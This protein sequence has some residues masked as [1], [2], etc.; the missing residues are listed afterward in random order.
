MI[1]LFA[2][3]APAALA[4][5]CAA[6]VEGDQ[7]LLATPLA[8]TAGAAE[9]T[10]ESALPVQGIR[11]L[12]AEEPM[13]TVQVEVHTDSQGSDTWN[14]R[15]SQA[16]A[17]AVRASILE[18]GPAPERVTAVG[19]GELYPIDTNSTAAGRAQ[20]RRVELHTEPPE[21]RPPRPEA[22]TGCTCRCPR[23][24]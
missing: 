10:P 5:P 9:I 23:A 12:M 4:I 3:F 11:C 20:N 1:V 14:L 7:V 17:D 24:P 8:F 16:Q 21:Q 18:G 19:Y 2:L 15:L 13:L 22:V 6:H